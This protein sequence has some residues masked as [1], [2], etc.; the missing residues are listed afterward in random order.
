M[1]Y[2]FYCIVRM[3]RY[4]TYLMNAGVRILLYA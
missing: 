2:A 4:N 3:D 1:Y